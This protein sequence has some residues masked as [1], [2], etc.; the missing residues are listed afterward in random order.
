[1]GKILS[2]PVDLGQ[3]F[4]KVREMRRGGK[5]A[6]VRFQKVSS[7]LF[8]DSTRKAAWASAPPET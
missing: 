2:A 5:S 8:P 4:W 7:G 3:V 1:M 6:P